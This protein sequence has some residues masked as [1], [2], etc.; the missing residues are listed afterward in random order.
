MGARRSA[1]AAKAQQVAPRPVAGSFRPVVQ[2]CSFRYNAKQRV[3]RGFTS[4]EI[5]AAGM[6]VSQARQV[7]VCVDKRRANKSAENLQRNVQRLKEYQSKLVVLKN[8]SASCDVP[9]NNVEHAKIEEADR[10]GSV[11]QAFHMARA[12]AKYAGQRKKRRDAKAAA[13]A[14]KA[15]RKK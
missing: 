8:R 12:N 3:G 11:Y 9:Q 6:S 10:K 5:K 7:G 2:A 1:R 13:E 15:G 4:E 14:E